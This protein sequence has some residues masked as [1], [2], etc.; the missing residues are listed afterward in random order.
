M[1]T[2]LILFLDGEWKEVDLYDNIPISVVIQETDLTDFQ[3]RKSPYSK[4][5]TVPGTMSNAIIF[6]H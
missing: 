6:E 3:G 1:D 4:Q 5:F 2:T